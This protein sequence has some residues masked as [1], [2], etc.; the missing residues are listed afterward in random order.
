MG[1]AKG[2][3]R[4]LI[5]GQAT[6]FSGPHDFCHHLVGLPKWNPGSDQIV[7]QV[8]GEKL[9]I[10]DVGDSVWLKLSA[11]HGSFHSREHDH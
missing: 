1:F 10:E 8:G 3:D 5:E 2:I 4:E 7:R 11:G 6:L 9:R